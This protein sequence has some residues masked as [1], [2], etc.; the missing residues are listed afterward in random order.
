VTTVGALCPNS[1]DQVTGGG[2]I[3]S[4]GLTHEM[5]SSWPAAF[6]EWAATVSNI[7]AAGNGS[8]QAV[9]VCAA[10]GAFPGYATPSTTAPNPPGKHTSLTESCIAPAVLLG[11]GSQSSAMINTRI[12]MTATQPVSPAGWQAGEANNSALTANLTVYA[13][14]A[15]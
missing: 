8:I 15:T 6:D 10:P 14:C 9:A 1:A 11:G 5:V 7:S 3:D 4:P 12:W 2:V 13:I